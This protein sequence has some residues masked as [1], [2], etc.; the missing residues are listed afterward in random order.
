M[1]YSHRTEQSAE[2]VRAMERQAGPEPSFTTSPNRY[3]SSD[4][5]ETSGLETPSQGNRSEKDTASTPG[6]EYWLP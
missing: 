5:R 2:P 1:Q 6:T 3:V 4:L